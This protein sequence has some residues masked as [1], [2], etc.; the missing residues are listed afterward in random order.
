VP[1]DHSGV[2]YRRIAG[3][4]EALIA[5]QQAAVVKIDLRL[6]DW[7]LED[8]AEAAVDRAEVKADAKAHPKR[9]A[10]LDKLMIGEPV[11][12][13]WSELWGRLPEHPPEWLS[14]PQITPH[15]RV[16]PDDLVEPADGPADQCQ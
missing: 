8:P 11:T 5:E 6:L 10:L 2:G 1:I 13:G 3:L 4:Y 9:S 12:V 16:Y 15:V 7:T 14:D